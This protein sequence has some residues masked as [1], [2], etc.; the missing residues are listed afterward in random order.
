MLYDFR[1]KYFIFFFCIL[2]IEDTIG[3]IAKSNTSKTI[4]RIEARKTIR[5]ILT[6][7]NNSRKNIFINPYSTIY[8]FKN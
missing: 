7:P 1:N 4:V 2:L 5:H 8:S 6:L 3:F